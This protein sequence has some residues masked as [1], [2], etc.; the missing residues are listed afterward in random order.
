MHKTLRYFLGLLL[1]VTTYSISAAEKWILDNQHTY[2]LWTIK[3][4]GFSYQTGK[5][6]ADGEIMLDPDNPT[7]SQVKATI[8]IANVITG[9]KELDNHLKEKLFFDTAQYPVATFISNKIDIVNKDC[10]RVHGMLSLH[11]VT[12]PVVLEV[13]LNKIGKHPMKGRMTAGF[14]A[15]TTIKRSD[16][17]MTSL[18]DALGDDVKIE[19][20][21]EAYQ[22]K[23]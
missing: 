7:N 16:F 11:G 8:Q 14:S 4:L 6:F 12:K 23:S 19:I 15:T 10:A 2:V 17:G 13:V 21:A 5:W 9:I 1:I 22:V 3:H 18:Q 20:G